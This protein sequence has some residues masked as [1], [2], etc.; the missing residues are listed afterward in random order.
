MTTIN[1]IISKSK[2]SI[3]KMRNVGLRLPRKY[4]SYNATDTKNIPLHV[5]PTWLSGEGSVVKMPLSPHR[6]LGNIFHVP[7]VQKTGVSTGCGEECIRVPVDPIC[8]PLRK[9]WSARNVRYGAPHCFTTPWRCQLRGKRLFI[10]SEISSSNV[11][12]HERRHHSQE[13]T[14]RETKWC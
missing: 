14:C 7:Y 4:I 11:R 12:D 6:R 1:E 10:A 2:K 9:V 13:T 5:L 8:A 3:L